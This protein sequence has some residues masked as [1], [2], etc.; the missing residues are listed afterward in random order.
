MLY[1][2]T[3][4]TIFFVLLP[5]FRHLFSLSNSYLEFASNPEP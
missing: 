5:V 2:A 3:Y 4:Q 1:P